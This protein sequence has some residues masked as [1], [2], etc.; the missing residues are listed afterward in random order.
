MDFFLCMYMH[1]P[2]I[3]FYY[4]GITLPSSL[5]QGPVSVR[6]KHIFLTP[7][8]IFLISITWVS[9]NGRQS[10]SYLHQF[11]TIL[12]LNLFVIISSDEIWKFNMS[13]CFL[14]GGV[15][16]W[17]F[18]V[19][20][21]LWLNHMKFL[22]PYFILLL[23]KWS[24]EENPSGPKMKEIRDKKTQVKRWHKTKFS[25]VERK[26]LTSPSL[27]KLIQMRIKLYNKLNKYV[28]IIDDI[29]NGKLH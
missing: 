7:C 15:W 23:P 26:A 8:C 4:G 11:R 10:I 3:F 22:T 18:K 27:H 21:F 5:Y 16:I 12:T 1:L 24:Y 14:V 20:S 2:Y 19:D 25:Q 6:L 13:F 17:R 28:L 29:I 9:S